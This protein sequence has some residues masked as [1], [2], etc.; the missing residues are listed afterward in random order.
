S[1]DR[2][3]FSASRPMKRPNS[4]SALA[5]C[6]R[7]SDASSLREM[8]GLP[9]SAATRG[10]PATCAANVSCSAQCGSSLWACASS[11]AAPPEGLARVSALDMASDL[12]YELVDQILVR[13]GVDLALEDLLGTGD[14]QCADLA[15]QLLA[16]PVRHALDFSGG[17]RLLL[18]AFDHRIGACLVDDLAGLLTGLVDDGGGVDACLADFV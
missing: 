17:D 9:N 3:P 18:G 2:R 5:P 8:R 16:R 13:V 10:S 1:T 12:G 6:G 15:A 7:N 4:E 14:G 11:T